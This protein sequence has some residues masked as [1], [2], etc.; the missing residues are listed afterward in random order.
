M[1]SMEFLQIA[2]NE[3][4]GGHPEKIGDLHE[5]KITLVQMDENLVGIMRKLVTKQKHNSCVTIKIQHN[6]PSSNRWKDEYIIYN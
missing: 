3:K 6:H 2:D 1:K 5:T 4:I